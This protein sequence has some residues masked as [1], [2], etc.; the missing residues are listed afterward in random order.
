MKE[1]TKIW[2]KKKISYSKVCTR[3]INTIRK[4]ENNKRKSSKRV[5]IQVHPLLLK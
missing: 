2:K 4:K 1:E 3:E 5:R